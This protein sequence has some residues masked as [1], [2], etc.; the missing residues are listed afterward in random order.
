MDPAVLTLAGH[1]GQSVVKNVRAVSPLAH[2]VT[3]AVPL[4]RKKPNN[5]VVLP[6]TVLGPL[7]RN[8][9]TRTAVSSFVTVV[10]DVDPELDT[11]VPWTKYRMLSATHNAAATTLPGPSGLHAQLAAVLVI[12][13]DRL[14]TV[15]ESQFSLTARFA[16]M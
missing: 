14:T 13:R 2:V 1:H 4:P 16:P 12:N 6:T 10:S 5:V 3:V 15:T 9:L 7:G 8:V 11:V